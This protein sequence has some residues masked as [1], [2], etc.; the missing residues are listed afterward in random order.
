MRKLSSSLILPCIFV[1]AALFGADGSPDTDQVAKLKA[2]LAE[3]QSQLERLRVALEGQQK[4]IDQML[5]AKP[6][7]LGEVTSLS[8]MAPATAPSPSPGPVLPPAMQKTDTPEPS[9]LSL[10]IGESYLTPLG[11]M[12]LTYVGRSTV[13]GS[14]IG[15]NFG[16]IPFNNNPAT[17]HLAENRL[18]PQNSR[19][20]F[21][22]DSLYKGAN[23]TGYF[24]G[25]FLGN[26]PAN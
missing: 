4:L 2:Q 7:N 20:G 17:G 1:A 12:D 14:G 18:N 8:P 15:T 21:R 19:S 16:S 22:F 13:S 23:V 9:P 10:K 11:F 6:K 5:T 3:Q 25:D 24:E 26:N